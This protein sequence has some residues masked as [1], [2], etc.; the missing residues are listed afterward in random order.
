MKLRKMIALIAILAV[1]T[2]FLS[3]ENNHITVNNMTIELSALPDA[4]DGYTIVHLSDLHSKEFGDKQKRLID[5]I[6]GV[7]PD[8]IVF[9]GDLID[10]RRYNEGSSL[11]LMQQAASIAPTYFVMGNHEWWSGKF[12]A[13]EKSLDERGVNVL[14]N[15]FA[16][17][18]NGSDEIFVVGIDDP[19]SGTEM[20]EAETVRRGIEEAL[21][22][23][24]ENAFKV[25]LAHRPELFP[26]YT[27][28]GFNL[29]LSG[30][31]HGGQVRLPF[32]GGVVAPNQG[33]LPRFTAGRYD[34]EHS[35]MVVHR[36]LGNS[37]F[38]QR[39]FNR[40]EL[41]VLTLKKS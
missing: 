34:I 4:F 25:L 38:P 24:E 36:G 28:Y 33:I 16:S 13:L 21:H 5:E 6:S 26:I 7:D 40:P 23:I 17:I 27:G 29:V 9:T 2:V 18:S 30:H 14:R 39:L 20:Y 19:A 15:T 37:I 32:I 35:V 22:G 41:I 8:L 10:R 1:M 11:E 12:S 3:F 31:A